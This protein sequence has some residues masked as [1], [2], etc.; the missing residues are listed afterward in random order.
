VARLLN[1]VSSL[2]DQVRSQLDEDN[3]EAI[4]TDRDIIPALNRAQDFGSNIL[5]RHYEDPLLVHTELPL[6]NSQIEYDIPEDAFED[7]IEK[8]EVSV[9]GTFIEMKR[10]SYRDAAFYEQETTHDVPYYYTIVGRKIRILP[11]PAGTYP[12]RVWYLRAPEVLVEEQGRITRDPNITG[13]YIVVDQVGTNLSDNSDSLQSYVNIIDG[14]TGQIKGTLQIALIE[15]DRITFRSGGVD[16]T[17]LNRTMSTSL[18]AL[19][20][21]KNDYICSIEGT[22][23]PQIARPMGNFLIQYAVA[24]LTRK[25]GGAADMEQRVLK[26]FEQQVERSWVGREATLRVKRRA[27]HWGLPYRR[28]YY[29]RGGR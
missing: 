10:L 1:T 27:K 25:L 22:A 15:S 26:D 7:R 17:V 6:V 8:L 23:V 19:G 29:P 5:A 11:K 14:Q 3:V 16:A 21:E 18:T 24:E 2:V 4:D 9:S 20:I 28:W 12:A 13:N